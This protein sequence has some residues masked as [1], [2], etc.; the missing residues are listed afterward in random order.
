MAAHFLLT[1]SARD[2]PLEKVERMSE[3][4]V[5][6]FFAQCRWGKDGTQVCPE[7]GTIARHYWVA[8]RKQW[9]CKE[10]ACGRAFS[11]TSG[12][13]F[14]DRK[15]PLR[16]ILKAM[17][18]FCSN[19]KGIS[20]LALSRQLGVAYQTAFVLAHKLRES[21][22][23]TTDRSQLAGTIHMDGAHVSGRKR[24]PRVKLPSTKKQAR[25][26]VPFSD[27]PQHRNRRIV[28]VMREVSD[29]PGAGALR[30]IVQVV[31]A[32][33]AEYV[34]GLVRKYI[35]KDAIVM[36]DEHPAYGMLTATHDHQTVNHSVEFS[37]DAGVNNNQAESYFSRL[38][39]L[40][41]GQVHRVTPAYMFDYAS[42]VAWREDRRRSRTSS[43]VIDVLGA[44][45]R[46]PSAWWRG[47][48]QGRRRGR[49]IL[50]GAA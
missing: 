8:T 3:A 25:D 38:R 20:A 26:R 40:V 23:E 32:E 48:W 18:I 13:K 4:R 44:T 46:K 24:K 9:R 27:D 17:V 49:E 16:T 41:I 10:L 50:F 28:M 47:Y 22:V 34:R 39:R 6:A 33:S 31:P 42:E 35:A 2:F 5:H 14:A 12:T 45:M 30:S 19:V 1:P 15:L 29:E 43:Q 37:T 21:I 7:C 36:T 11:V